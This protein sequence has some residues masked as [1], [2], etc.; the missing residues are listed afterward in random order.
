M[1][2]R[3][4]PLLAAGLALAAPARAESPLERL[5]QQL[6][7]AV[8]VPG[9][10]RFA[11]TTAALE[12]AVVGFC[13]APAPARLAAAR[14]AFVDAL[15]AWQHVQPIVFGPARTSSSDLAIELFPDSRG[16]VPRQMRQLLAAKEQDVL[17]PGALEGKSV[18][19]TGLPALELILYDD[20]RPPTVKGATPETDY[21]C[22]LAAAIARNLA[23]H[24]KAIA[25]AWTRPG[26][27]RDAL[28]TAGAGNDTYADAEEATGDYLKSLHTPLQAIIAVKLEEPL[29]KSLEKAKPHRAENWRSE[30]SLADIEANFETARALYVSP[31]GFGDLLLKVT[32]EAQLDSAIR[33]GFE[34]CLARLAAIK[35]PL[36][37][38]V[39]D[40]VERPKVGALVAETKALRLLVAN[41]LAPALD[42]GVGFNALDGD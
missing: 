37:V 7:D 13:A 41:Q 20:A 10:Q 24:G 17:P 34:R 2:L 38:A 42:L 1:Y 26:G 25:E 30:R 39:E 32:D 33:A 23:D 36:H 11:T 16:A 18:A 12:T 19:I 14:A 22:A 31:G 8:V 3:L 29:G 9:Y 5:N 15:D 6:A 4:L 21:A 27:F 28:Q 35:K 40:P